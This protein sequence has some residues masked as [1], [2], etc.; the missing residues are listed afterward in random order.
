MAVAV[1]II[2]AV[3]L[4]VAVAVD[5]AVGVAVALGIYKF[6]RYYPR[7]LRLA[8]IDD[9]FGQTPR[10]KNHKVVSSLLDPV[11]FP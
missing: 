1:G 3:D 11:P 10:L 8:R 7:T 9:K 2:V 5:Q 6:Q 4:A